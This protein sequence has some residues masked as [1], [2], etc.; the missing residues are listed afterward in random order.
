MEDE[1][2]LGIQP[3]L[4]EKSIFWPIK[5]LRTLLINNI[6][7]Y[8]TSKSKYAEHFFTIFCHLEQETDALKPALEA[9]ER[10][11]GD[12]DF[13]PCIPGNG[14]RSLL[15]VVE[16][17]VGRLITLCQHITRNRD[18][19]MFRGGHY[20]KELDAYS[21][22]ISQLRR[23]LA[24]AQN[25]F[26]YAETGEL[27]TNENEFPETELMEAQALDRECFY[28]RCLGFQFCDIMYKPL[29]T[30]SIAMASFSEGYHRYDGVIGRTAT[31]L[32]HSG[33]YMLNPEQRAK[34]IVEMTNKSDISFC[35][36]F[37]SIT[38]AS[39][40]SEMSGYMAGPVAV[41]KVI[42]VSPHNFEMP[43]VDGGESVTITPPCAHTGPGHVQMRLLCFQEREGQAWLFPLPKSK[44]ESINN[45][46]NKVQ[47]SPLSRSLLIHFHGGGFVAQT[48][49]SHEVYLR[50][51]CKELGVPILS[52]DYSLAPEAPFPRA[53]EECFFAYAWA[54]QNAQHLGS[55]GERVCI[56]GDSAGGNLAIS[57]AMR[58]ASY[59]IRVPDGIVA[60]YPP[61]NASFSP[62]PSRLL[63][64]LDPLLPFGVLMRCL[65]SYAGI[66]EEFVDANCVKDIVAHANDKVNG[67]TSSRSDPEGRDL[68][69]G[70]DKKKDVSVDDTS[71]ND[72]GI[73]FQV[74]ASK[75][76]TESPIMDEVPVS[77][78][79]ID[80]MNGMN[81]ETSKEIDA[82][83]IATV[84]TLERKKESALGAVATDAA[85][86]STQSTISPMV[87]VQSV[88]TDSTPDDLGPEDIPPRQ[89]LSRDSL[90]LD[91]NVDEESFGVI[92]SANSEPPAYIDSPIRK[93]HE[94]PIMRNAYLSPL[95]ADDDLLRGLPPIH[96]LAAS[97]DPLLDDSVT[98]AKRLKKLER[99]VYLE[100]IDDL[101]HGFLNFHMVGKEAREASMLC[102]R[103]IMEVFHGVEEE[104][105]WVEVEASGESQTN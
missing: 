96:L 80:G 4:G 1:G 39:V 16:K 3:E 2:V 70:G 25:V 60:A 50:S 82:V 13:D 52:V 61:L 40:V 75:S 54:V 32:Y 79:F 62:S 14:Y 6:E 92:D 8:Q 91:L 86:L 67:L 56:V 76:A 9:L 93:F 18:S 64:F 46:E 68:L 57:V 48:S 87:K 26:A 47:P 83:D 71:P 55:T 36:A 5:T 42:Q 37:W 19:M 78:F 34:R 84:V 105:E 23:M 58:A 94:K 30:V 99:P 29:Q 51:W 103:H 77:E 15:T 63:C 31:A 66:K 11:A 28:G 98:F 101:P 74:L 33:K 59:G 73:P 10:A 45:R 97:L 43:T 88:E 27:F 49:K 65:T 7:H 17:C 69:K 53:F 21:R 20:C 38:E 102:I 44:E 12:F 41:N 100:I 89:S 81:G 104:K 90:S 35:K 85:I 24:Y 22:A 95:K 72:T